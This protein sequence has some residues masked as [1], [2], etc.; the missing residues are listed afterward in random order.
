RPSA[1][2][3]DQR[4]GTRGPCKLV[5]FGIVRR[6]LARREEAVFTRRPGLDRHDVSPRRITGNRDAKAG[7]HPDQPKLRKLFDRQPESIRVVPGR[8]LEGIAKGKNGSSAGDVGF[9]GY[10]R[11]LIVLYIYLHRRGRQS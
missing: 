5:P 1:L 8:R 6:K 9:V 3:V 10:V 7:E 11:K 4:P 2:D